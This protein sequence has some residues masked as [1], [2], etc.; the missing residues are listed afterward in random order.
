MQVASILTVRT[1]NNTHSWYIQANRC[2]CSQV[3]IFYFAEIIEKTQKG[4]FCSNSLWITLC[5][6]CGICTNKL[7]FLRLLQISFARRRLLQLMPSN[8]LKLQLKS[9][10]ISYKLPIPAKITCK[11]RL[12]LKSIDMWRETK[13][14]S[15][16]MGIY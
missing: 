3:I 10:M 11:N 16:K 6:K 1:L 15:R 13:G 12:T 8:S 9:D 2:I 4:R 5:N 7:E 14:F